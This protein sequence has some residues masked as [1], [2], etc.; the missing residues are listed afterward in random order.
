MDFG[1]IL[2][3]SNVN[4]GSGRMG[5]YIAPG[6]ACQH[7]ASQALFDTSIRQLIQH[8]YCPGQDFGFL[9]GARTPSC[10][11]LCMQEVP[12]GPCCSVSGV[13]CLRPYPHAGGRL[14]DRLPEASTPACLY[15]VAT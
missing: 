12:C 11:N 13:F 7:A 9:C 8:T 3:S 14:S 1:A 15:C 10:M 2:L 6:E 5:K 4:M